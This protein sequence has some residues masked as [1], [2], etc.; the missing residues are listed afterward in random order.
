MK[1]FYSWKSLVKSS[2]H[3]HNWPDFIVISFLPEVISRSELPQNTLKNCSG[4][5][6]RAWISTTL[7]SSKFFL[8]LLYE[9]KKVKTQLGYCCY[10]S[11]PHKTFRIRRAWSWNFYWG[12]VLAIWRNT[13]GERQF[14]MKCQTWNVT[15]TNN[16]DFKRQILNAMLC[17]P[18]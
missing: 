17:H 3:D 16:S 2:L 11:F 13:Y 9:L 7:T 15:L 14:I 12:L 1:K 4:E 6:I 8:L 5:R 10:N 18:N